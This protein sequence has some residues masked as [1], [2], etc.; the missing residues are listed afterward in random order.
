[1]PG[2]GP[3]L[4]HWVRSVGDG[5]GGLGQRAEYG[6]QD[7]TVS[8]CGI[9]VVLFRQ[10]YFQKPLRIVLDQAVLSWAASSKH[11]AGATCRTPG[12]E[13]QEVHVN[14]RRLR[15]LSQQTYA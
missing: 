13:S 9:S 6:T 12:K 15:I 1:M 5:V 7:A 4:R 2:A 3:A 8:N 11:A 10:A 14:I